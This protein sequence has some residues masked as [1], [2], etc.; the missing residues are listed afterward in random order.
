MAVYII[1]FEANDQVQGRPSIPDEIHQYGSWQQVTEQTFILI[2]DQSPGDIYDHLKAALDGHHK[3]YIFTQSG[4]WF[5][6]G[7]DDL[8]KWV[9]D[10]VPG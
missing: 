4:S 5:G 2:T 8:N 10:N 6:F 3:L 9:Y 1:I 7:P